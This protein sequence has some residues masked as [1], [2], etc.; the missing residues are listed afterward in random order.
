MH[1]R[2]DWPL[3]PPCIALLVLGIGCAEPPTAD[4]DSDDVTETGSTSSDT[5]GSVTPPASTDSGEVSTGAAEGT[6]AAVDETGTAGS[7][8]ASFLPEMDLG[9]FPAGI[10]VGVSEVGH[11]STVYA[12]N[13]A[14]SAGACNPEPAP[15][16]GDVVGTW[17]IDTHCGFESLT[18]FFED[19]CPGSTMT[20]VA[21]ELIGTQILG[22]DG[23][24]SLEGDLTIDFDLQLDTETCFGVGCTDFGELLTMEDNNLELACTDAERAGGCDCFMTIENTLDREGTYTVEQDGLVLTNENGSSDPTPYCVE[25]DHLTLWEALRETQGYPEVTCDVPEDCEAALGDEH[26]QWLCV[27]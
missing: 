4:G 8:T 25:G 3:L 20:Y 19:E 22:D 17:S 27:Q 9:D 10:C 6:T 1:V 13:D 12:T 14:P 26:E 16:G 2:H 7:D 11:L 23:T 24:Y 5:T 18:N 21:S 15:C